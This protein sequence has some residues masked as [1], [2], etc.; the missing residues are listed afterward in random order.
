M[1][2]TGDNLVMGFASEGQ[3]TECVSEGEVKGCKGEGDVMECAEDGEEERCLTRVEGRRQ[4][5]IGTGVSDVSLLRL[6]L[7][8]RFE[9]KAT[10]FAD[11]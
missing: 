5:G 9:I 1:R 8:P 7:R 3:G 10:M 11:N 2:C 4:N 6:R